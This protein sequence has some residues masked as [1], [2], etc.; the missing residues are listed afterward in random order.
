MELNDILQKEIKGSIDFFLDFTNLD[1]NSL[2]YGLTVELDQET[3][4]GIDR[5][6][7][8]FSDSLGDRS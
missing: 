4:F 6:S 1:K 5:I 3:R 7:G 8:V 2:G